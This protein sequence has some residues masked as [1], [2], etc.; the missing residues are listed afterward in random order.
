MQLRFFALLLF[1]SV[2]SGIAFSQVQMLVID[3]NQSNLMFTEINDTLW[4]SPPFQY[5]W[6]GIDVTGDHIN[7]LIVSCDGY[8]GSAG[9]ESE[10]WLEG[11]GN[12]E[13]V[14]DTMLIDSIEQYGLPGSLFI[15]DTF[16]LVYK[17]SYGDTL[18][19]AAYFTA[20]KQYMV[21][22]YNYP[23]GM[24]G[25]GARLYL[26]GWVGGDHY[27]GFKTIINGDT[28]L[29]WLKVEVKNGTKIIVKESVVYDPDLSVIENPSA[30]TMIHPNP[31]TW[32]FQ[33]ETGDFHHME[34]FTLDGISVMESRLLC[35]STNR[36]N[37]S[38]L[39]P[40]LYIVRLTGAYE[41]L[42]QKL[43]IQ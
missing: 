16:Q 20:E 1:H 29:G 37:C 12:T 21:H 10:M 39:S 32:F 13:Y 42:T 40:G 25:P 17:Y 22:T 14:L 35:Q 4:N 5:K 24:F 36:F 6:L 26:H 28:Y 8:Q 31:A 23:P 7:D 11:I 27:I 15:V 18:Y 19:S 33:F 3:T 38:S 2:L 9:D 34:L 30:A 41:V 43:L